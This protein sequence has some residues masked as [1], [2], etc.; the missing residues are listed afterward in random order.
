MNE[1]KFKHLDYI[2]NIITR[3]NSNS[4]LIKGWGL[5]LISALFALASKD[6]NLNYVLITGIV[7]PAFWI[8]DGFFISTERQFRDLYNDVRRKNEEEI[9]FSMKI[10]N[11]GGWKMNW[12]K[13]IFSKT[14]IPYYGAGISSSILVFFFIK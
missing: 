6:A 14:L 5:T 3:M 1:K 12:I 4:F 10:S 13:G 2:Q 11:Y 8:L 7:L 9:D